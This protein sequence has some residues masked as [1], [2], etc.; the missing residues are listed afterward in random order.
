MGLSKAKLIGQ[1]APF[2]HSKKIPTL[3]KA[4][5]NPTTAIS[6]GT[7]RKGITTQHLLLI[8]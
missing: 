5:R 3:V 7:Q 4:V 1:T 2:L 8:F 6:G